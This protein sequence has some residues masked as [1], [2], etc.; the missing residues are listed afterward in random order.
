M[1]LQQGC[2]AG[3]GEQS[4]PSW[5]RCPRLPSL[6]SQPGWDRAPWGECVTVPHTRRWTARPFH[7]LQVGSREAYRIWWVRKLRPGAQ[8]RRARLGPA[9]SGQGTGGV[10]RPGEACGAEGMSRAEGVSGRRGV[11]G[12]G[13]AWPGQGRRGGAKETLL[14][15]GG[16][17]SAFWTPKCPHIMETLSPGTLACGGRGDPC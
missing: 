9:W 1:V 6:R 15:R 13:E 10:A 8:V 5:G 11:A 3:A 4:F 16:L 14:P 12:S 17:C 2:P 7:T